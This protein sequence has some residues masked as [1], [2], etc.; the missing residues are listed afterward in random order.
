M[1]IN[2]VAQV[3]PTPTLMAVPTAPVSIP[4]FGVWAS[5]DDLVQIWNLNSGV[6]TG[7]QYLILVGVVIVGIFVLVH[8]IRTVSKESDES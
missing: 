5:T 8:L 3:P 1:L 7:I 4:S 2:V 6:T